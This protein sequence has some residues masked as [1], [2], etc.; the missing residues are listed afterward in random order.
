M[1][2]QLF[3]QKKNRLV[4][5]QFDWVDLSPQR[6]S[7]HDESWGEIG[8]NCRIEQTRQWTYRK[9]AKSDQRINS[10]REKGFRFFVVSQLN[11]L[12][13]SLNSK[14]LK[15]FF[16]CLFFLCFDCFDCE[17]LNRSLTPHTRERRRR[18]PTVCAVE[19]YRV[20]RRACVDRRRRKE[21][22]SLPLYFIYAE[23]LCCCCAVCGTV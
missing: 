17:R 7:M 6:Q 13:H 3:K 2:L 16:A 11:S 23:M 18:E 12:H 22:L 5:R 10:N 8:G 19:L 15:H 20:G 9:R 4:H 1:R 14:W 21:E